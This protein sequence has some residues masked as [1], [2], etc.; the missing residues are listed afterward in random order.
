ML[1][2]L[3][4]TATSRS[5]SKHPNAAGDNKGVQNLDTIL[6]QR[7][8]VPSRKCGD[9]KAETAAPSEAQRDITRIDGTSRSWGENPGER[10]SHETAR[11]S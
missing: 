2:Q 4:E 10:V 1:E 11:A 6:V 7:R 3:H 8:C 9:T 5:W